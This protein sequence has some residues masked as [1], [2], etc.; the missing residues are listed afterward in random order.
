M[1][2]VVVGEELAERIRAGGWVDLIRP[3]AARHELAPGL[4]AAIVWQESTFRAAAVRPEPAFFAR[5][6]PAIEAFVRRSPSKVDDHWLRFPEFYSASYGPM[7]VLYQVALEH[8]FKGDFP[9]ELCVPAIGLDIGCRV[10]KAKQARTTGLRAAL[11]AYNGG[12]RPAYADEVMAKQA[13]LA[14]R[15][16]FR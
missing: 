7:Q 8:G 6:K 14:A 3:A 2:V 13:A 10:F 12:G 1:A 5:Y 16:L 15:G 9:T 11:L 4:V